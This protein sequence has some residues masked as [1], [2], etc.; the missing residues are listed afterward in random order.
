M[1]KELNKLLVELS[2]KYDQS[3]IKSYCNENGF[4]WEYYLI[5]STLEKNGPLLLGFNWGASQTEEYSPQSEITKTDFSTADSGSIKRSF[6]YLKKYFGESFLSLMTQSNYC[7]F[8]SHTEREITQHDISLCEPTFNKMISLL[9]P[10]IIISMSS[11]LREYLIKN[12]RLIDIESKIIKFQRGKS[13]VSI[14]A[15]KAKLLDGT[16]ICFLPHPNYPIKGEARDL[17]W[18]YCFS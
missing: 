15:I 5:Q 14:Q 12:E 10:S 4:K 9:E 8:R 7:F 2:A 18:D 3:D 11:Q 1:I 17:A 13:L 6:K 16:K